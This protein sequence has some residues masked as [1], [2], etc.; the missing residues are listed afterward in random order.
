MLLVLTMTAAMTACGG[1]SDAPA[2]D[3]NTP[4]T[5]SGAGATDSGATTEGAFLVAGSAIRT[6]MNMADALQILGDPLSYFEAESCAFNGLD[7]TYTYSGFVV[8]TRPDGEND[9]INSIVLT[10]DSVTTAKGIYIGSSEADVVAAYGECDSVTM[11]SYTFGD[12]CLNFIIADG[13]VIS[14]EYLEVEA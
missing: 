8:T 13:A 11:L 7:K 10:D 6:G 1:G 9:Y 4:A 5:E 14:I 2:Q 3:T 12:T